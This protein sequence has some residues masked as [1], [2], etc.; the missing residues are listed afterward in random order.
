MYDTDK[1]DIFDFGAVNYVVEV[2]FSLEVKTEDGTI[3]IFEIN[4]N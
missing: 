1:I 3:Y 2:I 4:L